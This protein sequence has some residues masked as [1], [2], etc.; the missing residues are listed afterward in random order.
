[1]NQLLPSRMTCAPAIL[2]NRGAIERIA[3]ITQC[4]AFIIS[5]RTSVRRLLAAKQRK[6]RL[7]VLPHNRGKKTSITGVALSRSKT[8]Q[9]S[10]SQ[11]CRSAHFRKSPVFI[12][13]KFNGIY[14]CVIGILQCRSVAYTGL[15]TEFSYPH[16]FQILLEILEYFQARF[17]KSGL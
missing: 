6:R 7:P 10:F 9:Q 3:F 12:P 8:Y 4:T 13:I 15:P 11:N 2:F 17:K 16:L 1:M 14:S 5:P